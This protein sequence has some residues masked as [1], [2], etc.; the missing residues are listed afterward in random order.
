MP[1]VEVL[2]AIVTNAGPLGFAAIFFIMWYL[3]RKRA[4]EERKMNQ[5]TLKESLSA[6]NNAADAIRS[7]RELLF[8]ER[9][10]P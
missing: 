8:R 10:A 5:E 1:T 9:P 6:A 3:E 4:D 7:L 2:W